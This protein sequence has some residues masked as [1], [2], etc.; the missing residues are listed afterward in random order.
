MGVI[1]IV[2]IDY[3]VA[4]QQALNLSRCVL[5]VVGWLFLSIRP[6]TDLLGKHLHNLK[7]HSK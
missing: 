1:F 2:S 5:V 4:C 7:Q 6:G 3:V